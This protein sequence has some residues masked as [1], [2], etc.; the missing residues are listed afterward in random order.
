M[1]LAVMA[2][3]RYHGPAAP[4]LMPE[5]SPMLCAYQANGAA[6]TWLRGWA[7]NHSVNRALERLG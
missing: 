2:S 4:P 6:A 3:T 7:G 1:Q 5:V